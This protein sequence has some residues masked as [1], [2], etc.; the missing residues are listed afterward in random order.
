MANTAPP[1]LL[2]GYSFATF[3]A[4]I[5]LTV[6]VYLRSIFAYSGAKLTITDG[7]NPDALLTI[8]DC[9]RYERKKQNFVLES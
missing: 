9:V 8:I 4:L 3:Y 7:P 6:G 1:A 5:V 2:A